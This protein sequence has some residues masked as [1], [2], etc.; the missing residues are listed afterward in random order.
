[1]NFEFRISD[2]E[3]RIL[4]FEFGPAFSGHAFAWILDWG[5]QQGRGR[6][7]NGP[8]C[9]MKCVRFAIMFLLGTN[10]WIEIASRCGFW[11]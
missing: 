9:G 8:C 11:V 6:C 1:M 7:P 2:F 4:N 10:K 3:F 5:I